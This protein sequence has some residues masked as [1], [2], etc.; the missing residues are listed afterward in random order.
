[1]IIHHLGYI[2]KD[3][4]KSIDV[5]FALGFK[6]SP[7]NETVHHDEYRDI[8]IFFIEKDGYCI[9]LISPSSKDS[10]FYPLLKKY[11]NCSYHICYTSD[12]VKADM[13]ELTMGGWKQITP[14]ES[15]SALDGRRVGFFLNPAIGMIELIEGSG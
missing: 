12:N 7:I 4:N 13:S 10:S 14:F 11:R 1:M 9:E 6:P 15:A 2:V 5:F 3:I 8:D